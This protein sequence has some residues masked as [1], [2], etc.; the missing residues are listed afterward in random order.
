MVKEQYLNNIARGALAALA[1]ALAGLQRIEIRTMDE[2]LGIPTEEAELIAVR[3]QQIVAY[4]TGITDTIDPLGGSYYLEHLTKEFEDRIV[5][6]ISRIDEMGGMV[7]AIE[8]GYVQK[9]ILEDAYKYQKEI[10]SGERVKVGF[11]KFYMPEEKISRKAYRAGPNVEEMEIER[12]KTTRASRNNRK[13][14]LLLNKIKEVAQKEESN[15]N[16]LM[17]YFIEAVR[18]Y[19]TIGEICNV[20]RGVFGEYDESRRF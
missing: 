5:A 20:L 10:E 16:N 13:V 18:E 19:T 8:T 15:E 4:E 2:V 12:V 3:C 1:G 11:N 6:E 7:K 14:A 17:P 9:Q